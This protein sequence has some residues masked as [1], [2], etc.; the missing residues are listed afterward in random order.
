MF[1]FVLVETSHTL[2]TDIVG[3]SSTRGEDDFLGIRT[4]QFGHLLHDVIINHPLPFPSQIYPILTARAFSTAVS[5]SQ[6]Y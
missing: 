5:V 1:L 3:F 4:D 6:P 2:Q